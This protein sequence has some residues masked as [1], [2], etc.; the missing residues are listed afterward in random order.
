MKAGI[1]TYLLADNTLKAALSGVTAVYSFPA[2]QDAVKPYLLISEVSDTIQ[3]TIGATLNIKDE[4]WQIDVYADTD[5]VATAI[6]KLVI[7]RMNIADRVEMGT[8]TVYSCSY[9]GGNDTSELEMTGGETASIRKTLTFDLVRD[10]T[11][12]PVTP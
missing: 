8:Y 9:S 4:S 5:A 12:T 11:V 2:P 6:K 3:N 10:N 7:A 1:R